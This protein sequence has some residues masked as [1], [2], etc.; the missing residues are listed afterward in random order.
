MHTIA[1]Q[2]NKQQQTKQKDGIERRVPFSAFFTH[3]FGGNVLSENEVLKAEPSLPSMASGQ[4]DVTH[5]VAGAW[6]F[7]PH[8]NQRSSSHWVSF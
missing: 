6:L 4:H 5:K 7:T 1:Q 8:K 3:Q 2:K